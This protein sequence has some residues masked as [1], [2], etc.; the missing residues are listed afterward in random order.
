MDIK[1]K[2]SFYLQKV[3]A[4]ESTEQQIRMRVRWGEHVLQFNVGYSIAPEKWNKKAGRCN[5]SVTNR[6]K[7]SAFKI[8]KEISRLEAL[9]D[10]VFKPFEVAGIIPTREE[11]KD[12]FN[13]ANGKI[14]KS[15][16]PNNITVQCGKATQLCQV[17]LDMRNDG[18]KGK[19][20]YFKG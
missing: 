15:T 3:Y 9:A 14:T 11:Y 10:D 7:V 8:N 12:A 13:A 4:G 20:V 18:K 17:H 5:K 1:R 16:S 19:V 2:I 6:K